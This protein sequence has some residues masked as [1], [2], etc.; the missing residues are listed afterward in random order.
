MAKQEARF[1]FDTSKEL[2][3]MIEQRATQEGISVS[4]YVREAILLELWFSGDL[5]AMKF[6]AGRVGKR[7]KDVLLDKVAR[8]DIKE[9]VEALEVG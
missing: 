6:L 3:K 5:E 9:R 2:G 1:T 4:E 8:V 7:V